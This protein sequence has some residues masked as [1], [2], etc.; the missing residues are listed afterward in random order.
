[1]KSN[2][3]EGDNYYNQ[4]VTNKPTNAKMEKVKKKFGSLQQKDNSYTPNK[5]PLIP[6]SIPTHFP[7]AKFPIL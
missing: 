2:W 7:Y 1:L 4:T 3:I 6:E 5:L